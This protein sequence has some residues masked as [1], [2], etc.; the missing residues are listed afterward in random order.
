[1]EYEPVQTQLTMKA[2]TKLVF[3]L[4]G[5]AT[6][7]QTISSS[8]VSASG[9]TQTSTAHKVSWTLGESVVGLMTGQDVQISNGYHQHLDLQLLSIANND[10]KASILVYPNPA[11]EYLMLTNKSN[12]KALL[13]VYDEAGRNVLEQEINQVE[14]RI[15]F[16]SFPSGIY[17]LNFTSLFS[18]KSNSYKLIKK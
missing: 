15:D 9:D 13:R 4:L 1:M 10:V 17:I 2:L 8:V 12:Q 5:L 3:L 6:N 7:A 18:L 16:K 14:T 11:T